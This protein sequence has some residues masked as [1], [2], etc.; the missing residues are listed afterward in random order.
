LNRWTLF[1]KEQIDKRK[2]EKMVPLQF[3]DDLKEELEKVLDHL[4]FESPVSKD[5]NGC[6]IKIFK[7]ML[8][9]KYTDEEEDPYPYI[10]VRLQNGEMEKPD[11]AHKVKV[12]IIIGIYE[13]NKENQGHQHVLNIIQDIIQ[14]FTVDPMLKN[15]YF[16]EPRID[17]ALSDSNS[18][19]YFFGAM[20]MTF[21]TPTFRRESEF[22]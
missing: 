14:R 13:R 6:K 5:K 22:A 9:Y 15:H 21:C 4:A 3:Q 8:P 12:L 17:W 18:Y 1:L 16:A 2:G 7:Q 19:P 20:E 10:I 11:G